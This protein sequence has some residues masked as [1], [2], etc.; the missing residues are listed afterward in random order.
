MVAMVLVVH[1]CQEVGQRVL[2]HFTWE[3]GGYDH[4]AEVLFA[5]RCEVD[6]EVHQAQLDK[7]S[8]E[9]KPAATGFCGLATCFC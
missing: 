3:V 9:L 6:D 5:D 7:L 8:V 4:C 2:A 1:Q